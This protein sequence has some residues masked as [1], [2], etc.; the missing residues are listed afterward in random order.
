[1]TGGQEEEKALVPVVDEQST[2]QQSSQPK[3]N[4]GS[5]VTAATDVAGNQRGEE[6]TQLQDSASKTRAVPPQ[7][8]EHDRFS[9]E[10]HTGRAPSMGHFGAPVGGMGNAGL[11]NMPS[12]QPQGPAQGFGP[13]GMANAMFPTLS[14]GGFPSAVAPPLPPGFGPS[15]GLEDSVKGDLKTVKDKV[16]AIHDKLEGW[17]GRRDIDS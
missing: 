11:G 16:V 1:M 6:S 14:F 8:N 15:V 4:N 5:E 13:W 7:K 2:H 17:S 9:S 10:Q 12:S 3:A